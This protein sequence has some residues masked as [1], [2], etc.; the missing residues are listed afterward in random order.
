MAAQS[1]NFQL[2]K[3]FYFTFSVSQNGAAYFIVQD[4]KEMIA[5]TVSEIFYMQQSRFVGWFVCFGGCI[6]GQLGFEGGVRE[7]FAF[8]DSFLPDVAVKHKNSEIQ[9]LPKTWAYFRM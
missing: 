1:T 2:N 4:N 9:Y 7:L 5:Q 6:N 3:W 8:G